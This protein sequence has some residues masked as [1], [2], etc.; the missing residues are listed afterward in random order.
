MGRYARNS[1]KEIPYHVINRG[2]NHQPI[3]F[4]EDDYLFFHKAL[5]QARKK[6]PCK[7]FSYV[8]MTNHFHLIIEAQEQAENLA[9]FMK[10]VCQRHGQYI[11]KR[12]KRS[13]SLWE[14][15]F[16]S[17]PISKDRYMLACS[18]Y[19]EMNPVRA[20]LVS[21]PGEYRHSS[22]RSKV[23]MSAPGY[24]S[25]D[26]CYLSLGDTEEARQ[27]EYRKLFECS[28]PEDEWKNIREAVQ[29]NW[30]YGDN[31]FRRQMEAALGRKF[32]LRRPG[33]KVR[34]NREGVM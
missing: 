12:Y 21:E 27:R 33:R 1:S 30:A 22:Y 24:V 15:R 10:Y 34:E 8:L 20:F 5:D 6:Y 19:I 28:I 13:G 4:R 16:R 18:R 3:F 29:R 25:F 7:I 9:G 11:N 17:S 23:G 26:P 31:R 14:G 32:E 2:N